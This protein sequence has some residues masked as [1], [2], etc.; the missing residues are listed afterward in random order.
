M[1]HKFILFLPFI[2]IINFFSISSI[3]NPIENENLPRHVVSQTWTINSD[4][5]HL[6]ENS[7]YKHYKHI[8]QQNKF[9]SYRRTANQLKDYFDECGYTE[10]QILNQHVLY[11]SN[12]FVKLVKTYSGYAKKIELLHKEFESLS[13]CKKFLR[14]LGA[15]YYPGLKK[16]INFLY[17]EILTQTLNNNNTAIKT[18]TKK[19][20][21]G[22]FSDLHEQIIDYET[23]I[24]VYHSYTPSLASAID[25]RT[26][27]YNTIISGKETHIT[28]SYKLDD[29][30]IKL[31]QNYGHDI[32]Q[33][34]QCI[35]NQLQHI[36]HQETIEILEQIN[37]LTECSVIY[38]HQSALVDCVASVCYYN[39]EGLIDKATQ[40]ADFCWTLLDYGQ[41]VIE[42]V[43]LG[44]YS[45]VNNIIENP[46]EATV[47]II[48]GKQILAYQLCK[49]LYNVADISVTAITNFDQ[50]YTKWNNYTEPLNAIISAI[51]NKKMSLRDIIKGG[52]AIAVGLKAQSKLLGGLNKFCNTIK[53]N[54]IRFAQKNIHVNPQAY[55]TTPEGMLLKTII[56]Q[57]KQPPKSLNVKNIIETKISKNQNIKGLLKKEGLP[58]KG[59]LRYVPPKKLHTFGRLP[60]TRLPNGDT[61]FIDRFGNIWTKGS[62]RTKGQA[63][64]W[65]VQ[66]SKQGISQVGWMTR[67]NSHLNVSLDGRVTHK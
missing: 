62:S 41:A 19:N 8:I 29:S 17:N 44:L 26:M 37:R 4:N 31:L 58:T 47:C 50:A 59:K 32:A 45:T 3:A 27:A 53:S 9:L 11:V 56:K 33:F 49:V 28:T 57:I 14:M 1:K 7:D 60:E 52:T 23:L 5:A 36:I 30:S 66:L 39:H 22:T 24:P 10:Q 55:L 2:T 12:E 46:L 51:Q 21:I 48:A 42:G 67:D 61:G 63:F 64:E 54:S 6:T 16:R 20:N 43:A 25:K 35:G 15:T 13:R 65:D 40:V 18:S 34:N 38:G